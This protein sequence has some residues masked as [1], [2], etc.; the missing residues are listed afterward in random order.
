MRPGSTLLVLFGMA[1]AAVSMI[2]FG[3][4]NIMSMQHSDIKAGTDR[5][6]LDGMFFGRLET[7]TFAL[8]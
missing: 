5:P 4:D 1:I 3:G 2:P 6:P 8:G 7:A